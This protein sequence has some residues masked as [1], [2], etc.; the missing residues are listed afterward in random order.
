[1]PIPRVRWSIPAVTVLIAITGCGDDR[2]TPAASPAPVTTATASPVVSPMASVTPSAP[3]PT[4][5]KEIAVTVTKKKVTPPTGRVEVRRGTTV[6]IIVTSDVADD[7]H[8]HGYDLEK[9][10][11]AGRP[12]SIEF[13]ADRAGLFEVETHE[14]HLVL[15]QLVVR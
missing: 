2:T 3:L 15:L 14:T 7:L 8:V 11:P 12:A 1:M 10:L 6:R 5:D 13:R 4:V 9:P